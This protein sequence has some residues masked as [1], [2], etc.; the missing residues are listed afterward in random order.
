MET[1]DES[2]VVQKRSPVVVADTATV[3][4]E[5]IERLD[6]TYPKSEVI[7]IAEWIHYLS[8]QD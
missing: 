1:P 4:G 8:T 6:R 5:V 7:K 2:T 3:A